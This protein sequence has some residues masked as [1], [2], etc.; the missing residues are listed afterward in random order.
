M[1]VFINVEDGCQEE[2]NYANLWNALRFQRQLE[3]LPITHLLSPQ[4]L[5]SIQLSLSASGS[6]LPLRLF[7]PPSVRGME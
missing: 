4:D 5:A 7:L 1:L 2:T 6:L 3:F